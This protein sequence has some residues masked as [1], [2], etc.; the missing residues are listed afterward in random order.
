MEISKRRCKELKISLTF[1]HHKIDHYNNV[2]M[3]EG[4]ALR[5]Q[6]QA[7]LLLFPTYLYAGLE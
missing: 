6:F 4:F 3:R 5:C 7:T 2:Y 1:A